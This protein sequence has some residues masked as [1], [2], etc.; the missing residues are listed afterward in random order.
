[1]AAPADITNSKDAQ[2]RPSPGAARVLIC[3]DEAVTALHLRRVL[4]DLGYAVVGEAGDGAEAVQLAGRL[5]PDVILMD[6]NMPRLDG[7][8][9]ARRIMA[10]HPTAILMLTAYSDP[11]LVKRALEAGASGYLVKPVVNEQ[12]SPAISVAQTRFEELRQ[13]RGVAASL[14][15][16]F[17]SRIP[18]IPGLQLAVRYQP[19]SEAARVGG[20][21]YDFIDLGRR[22]VGV[23]IGDVCGSGLAVAA[24]TGMARHMLRAYSVEDAAPVRVLERLNRGLARQMS[25]ESPYVTLFYGVLD[26][27]ERSLTYA[28]AGHPSPF[29]CEPAARRC[30]ELEATGGVVG[31]APEI[32]YAQ[33]N[34]ILPPGAVLALFT[35]G[36]TEAHTGAELLGSA[37]VRAAV[38]A[39]VAGSADVIADAI[40]AR[41]R[42]FG[43]G[44]LHDDVAIVVIRLE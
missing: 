41:A 22:R 8:E 6:V 40:L 1:M 37:G 43:G 7:I 30:R 35:D 27:E 3:E 16:S 18:E 21:F 36:V 34:V 12:L 29:L 44:E 9:A 24:F 25:E 13:E 38:E 14:V 23:V 4:T 20:D 33:Q 15:D 5:R 31:A 42:E 2:P 11:E 10:E 32:V 39:H 26:L 17:V 19:A 28:N